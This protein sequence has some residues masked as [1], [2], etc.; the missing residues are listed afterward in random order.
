MAF[1]LYLSIS[2]SATK[3]LY[4]R[5]IPL[6]PKHGVLLGGSPTVYTYTHC[7]SNCNVPPLCFLN[8]SLCSKPS[9]N[10][11]SLNWC[12]HVESSIEISQKTK[13]RTAIWHNSTPRYILQ[14]NPKMLIWKDICTPVFIAAPFTI[15]K[16][17][18][19]PKCPSTDEWIKMCYIYPMVYYSAMKR[20]K[21]L[22]LLQ[23]GR[24]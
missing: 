8:H 6:S 18:K 21:Q 1:K 20:M 7:F 19:Q 2:S 16:I 5:S 17:W 15:A 3:V 14:K 13:N 10:V 24:T 9:L 12:N 23:H 22:N 11:T 4:V